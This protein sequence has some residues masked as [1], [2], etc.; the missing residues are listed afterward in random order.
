MKAIEIKGMLVNFCDIKNDEKAF[1]HAVGG[2]LEHIQLRDDA[3]LICDR[4]AQN[5]GKAYNALASLIAR[6]A[7]YGS[8]IIIGYEDG[9]YCDPP[10][11]FKNFLTMREQ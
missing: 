3:M 7:V 10:E 6:T 9:E 8:A 4:D 11:S 2:S 1:R 5:S